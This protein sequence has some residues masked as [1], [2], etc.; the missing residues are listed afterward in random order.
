[1]P[2]K[3]RGINSTTSCDWS[4]HSLTEVIRPKL[5]GRSAIG[6]TVMVQ[7]ALIVPDHLLRLRGIHYRSPISSNPVRKHKKSTCPLNRSHPTRR[8]HRSKPSKRDSSRNLFNLAWILIKLSSQHRKRRRN[9]RTRG[10]KKRRKRRPPL[11]ETMDSRKIFTRSSSSKSRKTK[12]RRRKRRI[13]RTLSAWSQ[14]SWPSDVSLL[15][16][17]LLKILTIKMTVQDKPSLSLTSKTLIKPS[18]WLIES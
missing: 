9:Q 2:T 10:K 6:N 8:V 14:S 1:M 13:K 17:M 3:R 7:A 18:T 12:R 11:I 5:R 16:L 4:H 15:T